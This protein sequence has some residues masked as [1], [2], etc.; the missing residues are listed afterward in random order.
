[1]AAFMGTFRSLST[2][3]V[4]TII[5]AFGIDGAGCSHRPIAAGTVNTNVQVETS[6]GRFFPR[7][8]EGKSR[9][10]VEREAAIVTHVAARGVPTPPPLTTRHGQPFLEWN[11][12]YVSLFPWVEGRI[13]SRPEVGPTEAR[14]AAAALGRLHLAG[15]DLGDDRP[16]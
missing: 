7:G 5:A 3:E 8:N 16:G 10:D 2:D 15:A 9:P 13:L 6:R 12:S 1:M 14:A 4:T 11:G